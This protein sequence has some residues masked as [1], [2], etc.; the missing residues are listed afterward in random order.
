MAASKSPPEKPGST[1][2]TFGFLLLLIGVVVVAIAFSTD[3]SVPVPS[4]YDSSGLPDLGPREVTNSGLVQQ[5]TMLMLAGVGAAIVGSVLLV[6]GAII[7]A[8]R[9]S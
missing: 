2:L 5:Q 6:A 4:R 8:M 9:R 3:V 1:L 7:G